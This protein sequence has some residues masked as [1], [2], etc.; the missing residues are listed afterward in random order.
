MLFWG[1]EYFLVNCLARRKEFKKCEANKFAVIRQA[2]G[3]WAVC[4][5]FL[6]YYV[7][8]KDW[9]LKTEFK[10]T[11]ELC[12][13][14][15]VLCIGDAEAWW[16][17]AITTSL[18]CL[19]RSVALR[20]VLTSRA[21]YVSCFCSFYDAVDLSGTSN[22]L[23]FCFPV[24]LLLS[25]VFTLSPGA[26]CWPPDTARDCWLL[27]LEM[28]K[29]VHNPANL[30]RQLCALAGYQWGHERSTWG[31]IQEPYGSVWIWKIQ[32]GW[33]LVGLLK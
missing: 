22:A 17:A 29:A 10:L 12:L 26:V 21:A 7:M 27:L 4:S 19:L 23:Y 1:K 28:S 33:C 25:C 20:E 31:F 18:V 16:I 5:L 3:S 30:E 2:F 15:P 11:S 32:T 14:S 24:T 9:S 13:Y 8:R 6:W